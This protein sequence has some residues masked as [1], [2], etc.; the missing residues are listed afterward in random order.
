MRGNSV[1]AMICLM[2]A[3]TV[4]EKMMPHIEVFARKS[5]CWKAFKTAHY[6]L[7]RGIQGVLHHT[8]LEQVNML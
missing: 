4:L 5:K 3:R 6:F 7:L 1:D 2:A 8:Q